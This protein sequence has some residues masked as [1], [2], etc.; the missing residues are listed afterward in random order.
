MGE[1]TALKLIK[2]HHSIEKVLEN[3]NTGRKVPLNIP[4]PFPFDEARR[5]FK[6]ALAFLIILRQGACGRQRG[7]LLGGQ[8]TS[9]YPMNTR[10]PMNTHISYEYNLRKPCY[11]FP[12]HAHIIFWG[13]TLC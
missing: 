9:A 13:Y 6:G 7:R 11:G 2:E 12:R 4:E 8:S 10:I 1:K 5:L 3:I